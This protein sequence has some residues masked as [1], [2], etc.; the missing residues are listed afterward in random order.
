MKITTIGFQIQLYTKSFIFHFCRELLEYT[1]G[2]IPL[3][4]TDLDKIAD[5]KPVKMVRVEEPADGNED[6]IDRGKQAVGV[7]DD[8]EDAGEECLPNIESHCGSNS[9]KAQMALK[10]SFTLPSSCYATMAI[11]ELLKTSTSVCTSLQVFSSAQY[12]SLYYYF[13]CTII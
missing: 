1:D 6:R 7:E 2:N 13:N 8:D 5:Y 12:A 4:E 11:R 10:L 3:V 9:Q